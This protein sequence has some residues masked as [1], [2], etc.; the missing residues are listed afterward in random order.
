MYF[1]R[2]TKLFPILSSHV[3][4]M[5]VTYHVLLKESLSCTWS[6]LFIALMYM[7]R[8]LLRSKVTFT[9][10]TDHESKSTDHVPL[11][12]SCTFIVN[13]SHACTFYYV[14]STCVTFD[15]PYGVS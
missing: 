5:K 7:I 13:K 15:L 4:E 12:E 8:S 2:S 10:R 9:T 6:V 11:K 3:H 14:K 1:L